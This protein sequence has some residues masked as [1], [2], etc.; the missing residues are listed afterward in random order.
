MP[1]SK[2]RSISQKKSKFYFDLHHLHDENC[3]AMLFGA[4]QEVRFV[5]LGDEAIAALQKELAAQGQPSSPALLPF[6]S[7]LPLVADDT[8]V[9]PQ[10]PLSCTTNMTKHGW[11]YA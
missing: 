9:G 2:L 8:I 6:S 5:D 11:P 7:S 1:E 4:L 3:M 10:V